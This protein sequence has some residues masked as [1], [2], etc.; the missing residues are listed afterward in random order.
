LNEVIALRRT[1][2][3]KKAWLDGGELAESKV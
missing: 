3:K 2:A 1:E